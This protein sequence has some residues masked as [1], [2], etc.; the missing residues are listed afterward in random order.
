MPFV[1]LMTDVNNNQTAAC[2]NT[3]IPVILQ[4]VTYQ[5]G[6]P[7]ISRTVKE[8]LVDKISGTPNR[9][10]HGKPSGLLTST[11]KPVNTNVQIIESAVGC[12]RQPLACVIERSSGERQ[13]QREQ[14]VQQITPRP[15]QPLT[16]P[17]V[18]EGKFVYVND[19]FLGNKMNAH[20]IQHLVPGDWLLTF[21][22][23]SSN[24]I[25]KW[26]RSRSDCTKCAVWSVIYPIQLLTLW[27]F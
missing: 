2:S 13:G 4:P 15:I 18:C 12:E 23:P 25:C 22:V 24:S 21:S 9:T 7:T 27:M 3:R 11:C 5:Y 8:K 20:V 10:G 14:H 1:N 17:K 19:F 6:C 26:H 16:T